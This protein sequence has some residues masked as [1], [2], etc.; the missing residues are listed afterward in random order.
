[1]PHALIID[2][3]TQNIEILEALL[4]EEGF[5]FSSIQSIASLNALTDLP[6]ADIIF[7]DFEMPGVDGYQVFEHLHNDARF[8]DTPI[9][10]YTVHT[11][12]ARAAQEMGFHSFLGK[13]LDADDFPDQLH[14]ILQGEH[15]WVY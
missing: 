4:S 5:N 8:H 12:E 14:R 10:A 1:M 15:V 13:P 6:A 2:D 3:N 7:L 9:V 11:S